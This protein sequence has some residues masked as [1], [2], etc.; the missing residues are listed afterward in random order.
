LGAQL[1]S[2]FANNF[3]RSQPMRQEAEER[4]LTSLT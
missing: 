3:D 1:P 2:T 4:G